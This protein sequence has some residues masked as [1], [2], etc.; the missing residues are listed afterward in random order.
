MDTLPIRASSV[1]PSRARAASRALSDSDD[2]DP[3]KKGEHLHLVSGRLKAEGVWCK[4]TL[5]PV[6]CLVHCPINCTARTSIGSWINSSGRG[7]G[8]LVG[9]RRRVI[10]KNITEHCLCRC[11]DGG[12]PRTRTS[13]Q[14]WRSTSS[15]GCAGATAT[16]SRATQTWRTSSCA[17]PAGTMA[18]S[19]GR[20]SSTSPHW[21]T[22]PSWLGGW[23]LAVW[24][25]GGR[26]LGGGGGGFSVLPL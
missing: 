20:S 12:A 1:L 25:E 22:E 5:C 13:R 24:T 21:R 6:S 11:Q 18:P 26:K 2:E 17:S 3:K 16:T 4:R 19:S 8:Y 15:M 10:D 23:V 14:R 7:G 9:E